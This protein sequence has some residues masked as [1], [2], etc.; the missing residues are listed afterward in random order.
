MFEKLKTF[1]IESDLTLHMLDILVEFAAIV[2]V[3]IVILGIAMLAIQFINNA[4]RNMSL[5]N[6]GVSAGVQRIAKD[7]GSHS[8]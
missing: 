6:T 5:S 1:L 4:S 8:N 3:G 2:M 7:I